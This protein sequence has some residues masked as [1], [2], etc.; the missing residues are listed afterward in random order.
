M[1][2]SDLEDSRVITIDQNEPSWE[3][4]TVR[5]VGEE[6]NEGGREERKMEQGRGV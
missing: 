6:E 4:G 5:D 2:L 1:H 3:K